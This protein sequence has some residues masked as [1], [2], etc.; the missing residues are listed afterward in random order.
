[1]TR[2]SE[3]DILANTLMRKAY[4]EWLHK[5]S[6]AAFLPEKLLG[7]WNCE[8]PSRISSTTCLSSDDWKLFEAKQGSGFDSFG[9]FQIF[10][11]ELKTID[12]I[13]TIN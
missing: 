12:Y 4:E 11:W 10:Y 9:L 3:N 6:S 8:Q 2:Y 1:M 7:N 13:R 5:I